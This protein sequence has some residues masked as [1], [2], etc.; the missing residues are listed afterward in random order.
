MVSLD[1]RVGIG[2]ASLHLLALA[3]A[4]VALPLYEVLSDASHF[5]VARRSAPSDI[6]TLVVLI[7]ILVPGALIAIEAL[8]GAIRRRLQVALHLILVAALVALYLLRLLN[9][10]SWLP[11]AATVAAVAAGATGAVALCTGC[12]QVKGSDVCCKLPKP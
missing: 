11:L 10:V 6:L 1:R 5:F 8:A 9:A 7:S 3:G 4:S 12:G 2:T